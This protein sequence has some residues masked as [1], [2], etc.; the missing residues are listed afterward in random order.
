MLILKV[1]HTIKQYFPAHPNCVLFI[2]HGGLQSLTEAVFYGVPL[3]GIPLKGDQEYNVKAAVSYGMAE[4]INKLNM[5][6]DAIL[7]TINT[8]LGS[9][10]YVIY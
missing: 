3:V 1:L 2:T 5:T 10:W 4:K 7:G 9:I 8:V 6:S